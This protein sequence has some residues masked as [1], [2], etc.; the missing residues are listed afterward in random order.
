MWKHLD[1]N[2]DKLNTKIQ[3]LWERGLLSFSVIGILLILLLPNGVL[4]S[5]TRSSDILVFLSGDTLK[6]Y[7]NDS[8]ITQ[9]I[10]KREEDTTNGSY[11][12]EK[13]GVSPDHQRFFICEERYFP[14]CDSH[15]TKLS[16]Y[17]ANKK[18][19]FV[20]T[21]GGKRKICADLT[22]IYPDKIVF[23]ITD[24]FND[25]PV[26]V[27]INKNKK[28]LD[29][30]Q[31]TSI[32]NY[33]FSTNG[34]YILFHAKKPYNNRLWDYI[35]FLDLT[36]DK[37]WEYLFPFCFSCKRGWIDLKVYDDGKSEVIYR[38][39]HRVFDKE[40]HLLDIFVKLD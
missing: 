24:R 28:T 23:F 10:L 19:L 15:Y 37:S 6:F 16:V 7:R 18:K 1:G 13:A 31:W 17:T 39:E 38:N 9:R 12:F 26:M 36:T 8:L 14:E 29:L 21:K 32:T 25:N 4:H 35:Y 5:L 22:R 30:K 40:G 11:Y 33:A 20:Y 2:M 27:I 34:R 3:Q